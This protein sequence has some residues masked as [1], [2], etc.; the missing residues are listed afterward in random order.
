[1][2]GPSRRTRDRSQRWLLLAALVVLPSLVLWRWFAGARP[3]VDT[4]VT[5]TASADEAWRADAV[6]P[7]RARSDELDP[8]SNALADAHRDVVHEVEPAVAK[9]NAPAVSGS[10]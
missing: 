6:A 7:N 4:H 1:M 5:S 10:I 3:E 8:T 2:A 9:P